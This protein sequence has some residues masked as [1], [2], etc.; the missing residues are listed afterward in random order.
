M[1]SD[2]YFIILLGPTGV[3]KTDL[4][5]KIANDMS[6]KDY[7]KI[8]IDDYI[9]ESNIFNKKILTFL[10]LINDNIKISINKIT[11]IIN[12]NS[13]TRKELITDI[14]NNIYYSSKNDNCM[15]VSKLVCNNIHDK[16]INKY[17]IQEKNIFLELNGENDFTW[18]FGSDKFIEGGYYTKK[19]VNILN[20]KYKKIIVYCGT[21]YEDLI[22]S[23]QNRFINNLNKCTNV[24][25]N[26]RLGNFLIESK[27][28]KILKNI[29]LRLK[30]DYHKLVNK[31]KCK[32]MIYKRENNSYSKI[33]YLKDPSIV[34]S[35]IF[36]ED[37][38]GN[39][40]HS[41]K[42]KKSRKSRKTKKR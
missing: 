28:S 12:G 8:G 27:Y 10:H 37:N 36:Y 14:F 4:L 18:F 21:K 25:C 15:P 39:R 33:C 6:I 19:A 13:K 30:N 23:N 35:N 1:K 11:S 32:I 16:D 17:V 20:T 29:I 40:K 26:A 2:K 38:I 22:I 42:T 34:Y 3:G 41:R 7:V 24:K 31:Y 9:E 5:K